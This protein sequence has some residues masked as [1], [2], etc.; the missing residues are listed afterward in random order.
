MTSFNLNYFLKDPVSKYLTLGV[1][2]LAHKTE[3]GAYKTEAG[4]LKQLLSH[5]IDEEN[6]ALGT[7]S[8]QQKCFLLPLPS[9]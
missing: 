2:V 4:G 9:L 5:F 3:V 8:G 6:K 1:R 7:E